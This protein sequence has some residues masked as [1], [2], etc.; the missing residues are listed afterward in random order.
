MDKHSHTL[1]IDITFRVWTLVAIK[2]AQ[3]SL[4]LENKPF[5]STRPHL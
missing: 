5:I 3:L 4:R 1:N 2:L